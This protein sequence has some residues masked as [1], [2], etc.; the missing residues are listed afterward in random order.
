MQSCRRKSS[1]RA[2]PCESDPAAILEFL[3]FYSEGGKQ[4]PLFITNYVTINV[5]DRLAKHARRGRR[6]LFGQQ[7]YSMRVWFNMDRLTALHL[8]PADIINAIQAQN[9]QAAVGRHRRA[10]DAERPRNSN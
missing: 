5:L 3:Q 2:S 6:V 9:V 4:D 1:A 8:T 10:P 7:D